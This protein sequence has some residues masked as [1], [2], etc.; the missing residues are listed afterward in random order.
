MTGVQIVIVPAASAAARNR[1]DRYKVVTT[2]AVGNF[3]ASG[4][5]PGAYTAFAFEQIEPGA[6]FVFA[7]DPQMYTSY[8][9]RGASV[10]AEES[11]KQTVRLIVV[12]AEET[13]GGIR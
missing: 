6:Y 10:S 7:Y 1:E 5:A 8:R 4:I 12:P 11:G 2:D 13:A 3:R 9:S